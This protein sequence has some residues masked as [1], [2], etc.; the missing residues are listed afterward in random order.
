MASL[1]GAI[2][3]L[4]L[5]GLPGQAPYTQQLGASGGRPDDGTFTALTL[6]GTPGHVYGSF[7]DKVEE[8]SLTKPVTDRLVPRLTIGPVSDIDV[9]L[10]DTLIPVIRVSAYATLYRTVTDTL[11]PRLTETI[12]SLVKSGSVTI[13]G[14]DTVVPVLTVTAVPTRLINVTDTLVPVLTEGVTYTVGNAATVTESIVPVLTVTTSLDQ[15]VGSVNW[16]RSDT[17]IPVLRVT[18][19]AEAAGEVDIIHI[20][21]RPT[22]I[23]R[24]NEK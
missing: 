21:L 16:P 10:T 19:T 3:F 9:D 1:T 15:L 12:P 23:I 6:T 24:I 22:G 7:A 2:T 11:R 17:L 13:L 8:T 18:A 5:A 4:T 14:T 20:A